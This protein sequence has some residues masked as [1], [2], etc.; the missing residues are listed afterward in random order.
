MP[1]RTQHLRRPRRE[2]RMSHSSPST[3]A[4]S[5]Q[6]VVA[7]RRLQDSLLETQ[8]RVRMLERL[9]VQ[10][11][12]TSQDLLASVKPL[13]PRPP[14][15]WK[16]VVAPRKTPVVA[17]G[18]W[19]DWH[20][21]QAFKSDEVQGYGRYNV[22]LARQRIADWTQTFMRW[23][24]TQ[25]HAY[26][27]DECVILGVADWV[28]G[29]IHQE[30][31]IYNEIEPIPSAVECGYEIADQLSTLSRMFTVLRAE[32]LSTDNHS[33]L[34]PKILYTGRGQWSLGYVV[35]SIA[36]AALQQHDNVLYR[37]HDGIKA[38][39]DIAGKLFQIEHGNDIRGWM[40]LPYYGIERLVANEFRRRAVAG[41]PALHCL[42]L[43][44]FHVPVRLPHVILNG[45]LCGTTPLD[46][47]S[48]RLS[49]PSQYAFLVHP[50]HGVF[51]EIQIAPSV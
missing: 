1:S 28:H 19:G 29:L 42:V 21:G 26:P 34:T 48:A 23:V 41:K 35:N 25:R 24:Q 46:H 12:D 4:G 32:M 3:T 40:G 6:A 39:V 17:V 49:R 30:N 13:T 7:E 37:Q 9:L 36:Q 5:T 27:I 14:Y 2:R 11:E 43:G 10:A 47:A 16:S 8:Q 38:D 45:S 18:V 15:D 22:Q 50:E 44:H 20:W 51:N 33:R 31:F